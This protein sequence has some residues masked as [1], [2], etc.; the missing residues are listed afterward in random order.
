MQQEAA[1]EL[2]GRDAACSEAA[3]GLS[4]TTTPSTK[5][6]SRSP[7]CRAIY[8]SDWSRRRLKPLIHPIRSA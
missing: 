6:V 5:P 1:N 2:V 4:G 8:G 7:P 3:T